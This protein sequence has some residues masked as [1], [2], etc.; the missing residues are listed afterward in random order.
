MNGAALAVTGPV[1]MTQARQLAGQTARRLGFPPSVVD[2]VVLAA[3]ELGTN[4]MKYATDG[5]LV[6]VPSPGGLDVL[7]IDRGPGIERVQ[8]S[9]RDGFSTT[10][11]LGLGLGGVRRLAGEF[12]I[13][14]RHGEGTTVLA[15]WRHDES[16]G[17][18]RAEVV[19]GAALSA[20]PGE[21]VC[22]D[23]WVVTHSEGVS[24]VVLSDGLGHGPE[25]AEASTA[26]MERV[27]AD[28]TAAP[29]ELIVALDDS[30]TTKRGATV[31]IAQFRAGHSTMSFCG[32]G[33]STVRLI[34]KDGSYEAL[35][36]SPG[37]VGKRQRSGKRGIPTVRPWSGHGWLVMHTD[38]VSDRWSAAD[39]LDVLQHDPATAAGWLFGAYGRRRD[40]ACVVVVS[41]GGAT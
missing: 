20:A 40:D 31:A 10:G 1:Q 25:A 18:S 22:G 24:T 15:R 35:V 39:N 16:G 21:T 12:D 36:S 5:Q 32:V 4:L 17:P 26:V 27:L 2:R 11:T 34:A 8:D 7:A 38:G 14:S 6:I 41:G 9:M 28:P 33:N 19:V 13:F 3:S 29:E 37:I 23:D 30:M